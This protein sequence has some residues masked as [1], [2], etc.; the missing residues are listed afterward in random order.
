M[1]FGFM[2]AAACCLLMGCF[3]SQAL[4]EVVY[5]E[6]K[7]SDGTVTYCERFEVKNSGGVLKSGDY[8]VD[9]SS[10]DWTGTFSMTPKKWIFYENSSGGTGTIKLNLGTWENADGAKG[11]SKEVD[12]AGYC[13]CLESIGKSCHKSSSYSLSDD[14]ALVEL[15]ELLE[16]GEY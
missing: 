3:S 8:E 9:T 13:E 16:L 11:T 4:A 1:K 2:K 12:Y 7:N 5:V 15:G 10:S 6:S 14:S